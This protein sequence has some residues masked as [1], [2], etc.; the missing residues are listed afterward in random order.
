MKTFADLDRLL[1]TMDV[2]VQTFAP[3]EVGRGCRFAGAPDNALTILYVMSGTLHLA[4]PEREP[5]ICC[6]GSMILAPPGLAMEL[7]PDGEAR[8]LKVAAGIVSARLSASFGLLDRA[9]A[10]IVE[11][12]SR[13]EMVR[14]ACRAMFEEAALAEPGLGSRAMLSAL[15]KSCILLVLRRFF[16][17]PG[18][19]QKIVSALAEPRLAGAVAMILDEPGAPHNVASLASCAGLSRSTFTR[20]FTE[21]LGS[22]PMEFVA[23]TR[24]H[25]AA[26]ML[27]AT[28]MPI[29]TIA[30]NI[31][32]GSRSHFS[33]AFREA[34]GLDPRSF[35]KVQQQA[36]MT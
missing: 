19:N 21:A 22:S 33:R 15:M 29:K 34:H 17:R 32:F 13:S 18:I 36:R 11:D 16:R 27:R 14:S 2:A 4:M 31:G 7:S 30:A 3:C 9:K 20:H 25:Y 24:L 12:M 8:D 5:R 6:P 23:K 35:R 28:K 26:D 10:P 1:V